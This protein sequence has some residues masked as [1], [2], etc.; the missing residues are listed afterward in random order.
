MNKYKY[1]YF[2]GKICTPFFPS[3]ISLKPTF[4]NLQLFPTNNLQNSKYTHKGTTSIRNTTD[5]GTK[6]YNEPKSK[7]CLNRALPRLSPIVHPRQKK[8]YF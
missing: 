8:R 3:I 6:P 4:L 2:L 7:T 1:I 5:A